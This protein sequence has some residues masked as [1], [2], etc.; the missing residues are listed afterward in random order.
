MKNNQLKI[1]LILLA[2]ILV[3]IFNVIQSYSLIRFSYT[4]LIVVIIF[5]IIGSFIQR[6]VNNIIMK[7]IEQK[8]KAIE[9]TTPDID[10]KVG[11]VEQVDEGK[12]E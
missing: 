2:A 10:T 11:Q 5:Y 9:E 4:L 8:E 12:N 1:I 7:D 3:S 6:A